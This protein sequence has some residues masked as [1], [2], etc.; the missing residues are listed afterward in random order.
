MRSCNKPTYTNISAR[1]FRW[2][3]FELFFFRAGPRAPARA[4]HARGAAREG[5]R[6]AQAQVRQAEAAPRERRAR[7]GVVRGAGGAVMRS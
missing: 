5:R 2:F 1:R 4:R 7:Q 6:D 3:A